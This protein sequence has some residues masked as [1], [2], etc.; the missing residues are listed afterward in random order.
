MLMSPEKLITGQ[1]GADPV[2]GTRGIASGT[3]VATQDGYLPVDFLEPGERV[4]TRSGMR[5]LRAVN[6]RRYSG[7]AVCIRA[8]ALGHD[9]PEQ[10]LTLP[11]DTLILVRDWRASAIW[12]EDQAMVPVS[13]LID[14][15]F[16]ALTEVKSLRT[17]E[18][19]FDAP[20]IIYAE[21]VEL[22]CP[23]IEA[24]AAA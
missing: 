10:D 3:V 7:P 11:S 15:E 13:R 6:V 2:A 17:F 5:V 24:P 16:V 23:G 8:S 1:D 18:L 20:E 22:C 9:R 14:G 19:V 21:G 12:D 4:I